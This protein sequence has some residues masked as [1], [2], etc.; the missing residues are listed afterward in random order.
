MDTCFALRQQFSF[1]KS[2]EAYTVRPWGSLFKNETLPART[3]KKPPSKAA[4]A[5]WENGPR[6]SAG[7]IPRWPSG[8]S[9]ELVEVHLG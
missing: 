1:L 9:T 6:H 2:I 3:L 5:D 8:D 4:G 7:H